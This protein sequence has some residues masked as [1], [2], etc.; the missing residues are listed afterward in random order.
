MIE[1][2]NPKWYWKGHFDIGQKIE[3]NSI[4]D[5]CL[6][7][8]TIW[9]DPPEWSKFCNVKASTTYRESDGVLK[10]F[11][12]V[13]K[14][15]FQQFIDEMNWK[16]EVEIKPDGLWVNKYGR[17]DHQEFHNHAMSSC[18]I[19]MV[20]FHK[21]TRPTFRF[22]DPDWMPN[23]A[24]GLADVMELPNFEVI[25]PECKQGDIIIFP[26]QYGHMVSPNESD[27]LRITV[28]G[29]FKVMRREMTLN[30]LAQLS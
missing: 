17:N 14:P 24:S 25:T 10:D 30:E 4:I 13:V 5:E 11:L 26:S 9:N 2:W 22:F 19:S 1:Y 7:D 29:N 21:I 8:E 15:S 3:S 27:D 16:G 28:S 20:Y 12:D 23:R 18:N 6:R